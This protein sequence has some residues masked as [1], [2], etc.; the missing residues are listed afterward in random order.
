MNIKEL[1]QVLI[2]NY[3]INK[4]KNCLG[5]VEKVVEELFEGIDESFPLEAEVIV[6]TDNFNNWLNK[7]F[8]PSDGQHYATKDCKHIY[9]LKDLYKK[10]KK[11]YH[12]NPSVSE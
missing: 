3:H 4:K 5:S 7:Y 11:A 2:K 9:R 12:E 8:I 1:K 10:F 6:H